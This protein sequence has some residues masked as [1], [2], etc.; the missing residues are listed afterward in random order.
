MTDG[1]KRIGRI[2]IALILILIASY[3]LFESRRYLEG[4][5][6]TITSPTDGGVV[7]GL[8]V[9]VTGT[10]ENLSYFY[11]NGSQAFLNEDGTFSFLY[12]PPQGYTTLRARG[13]DR[14]GRSTEVVVR[15]T[16]EH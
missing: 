11:I 13:E 7:E 3:A 14:F 10:G 2:G 12:T 9:H 1:R 5:V 8:P 4:P 16:V 6:I 15:F